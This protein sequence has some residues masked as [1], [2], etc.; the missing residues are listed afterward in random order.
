MEFP[1]YSD[2]VKENID[3]E[4][5]RMQIVINIDDEL[6]FPALISTYSTLGIV[7]SITFSNKLMYS[8]ILSLRKFDY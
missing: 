8:S 4:G 6:L 5:R 2:F 7:F 1:D 3:D